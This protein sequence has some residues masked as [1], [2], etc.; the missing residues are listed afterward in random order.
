MYQLDEMPADKSSSARF[1]NQDTYTFG[2]LGMLTGEKTFDESQGAEWW[3]KFWNDNKDHLIWD[4]EKGC[5][6]PKK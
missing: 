4:N 6:K 5:F 3:E 2:Y 1:C